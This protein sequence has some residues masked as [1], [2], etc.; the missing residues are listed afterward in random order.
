[1]ELREAL[2]TAIAGALIGAITLGGVFVARALLNTRMLGRR[3]EPGA[4]VRRSARSAVLTLG[5]SFVVSLP[6]AGGNIQDTIDLEYLLS[7]I[8]ISLQFL[9]WAGLFLALDRG[10]YFLI[11]HYLARA[12][13]WVTRRAPWRYTTFLDVAA[14]RLLLRKVGGGYIFVHRSLLEYLARVSPTVAPVIRD[15]QMVG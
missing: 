1:M 7:L 13:L 15:A 3:R 6:F 4:L 14:E 5:V 9:G 2:K 11:R 12:L 10:G 8:Q